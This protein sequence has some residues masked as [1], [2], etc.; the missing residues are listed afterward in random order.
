[1]VNA[2]DIYK[3]L[4]TLHA[5]ILIYQ[6]TFYQIKRKKER[7]LILLKEYL[8]KII[9]KLQKILSDKL[10]EIEIDDNISDSYVSLIKKI[11]TDTEYELGRIK[12]NDKTIQTRVIKYFTE[13]TFKR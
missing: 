13:K 12:Y 9:F 7:N 8:K 11:I 2:E 5:S 1:M 10:N 4:D 6:N 3:S